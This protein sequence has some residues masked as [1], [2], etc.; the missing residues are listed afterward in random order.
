MR[1][2][3]PASSKLVKTAFDALPLGAIKPAGWLK[4]QLLIQASGFS[5]HLDE[6]WEDVGPRN[7]WIGGDGESWERG[8]Y[9]IDG[10]LPLA[11]LLEDEALIAKANKWVEWSLNSQQENGQFGPVDLKTINVEITKKHDWWHYMI[12]LKVMTQFAEVTGDERVEPFMTKFFRYVHQTIEQQ[13]LVE[14]AEARGAEMM[15]CIFWLYKRTGDQFLLELAAIVAKQTTDWTGLFTDFPFWNKV[16]HWDHRSHVVNVAMGIK[17]PGTL[18]EFTGDEKERD[19]V[20]RGIRSLMTYHGQ[21]HGM[22]SGDEWLSGTNPSQGVETCAVVEYMFSLENLVRIFG[23]GYFGDILEKVTFNALPAPISADWTSRQ[24]DQQVNQVACNIAHRNW[25][26]NDEA[27]LFGFDANFGCC[28]ANMHQGWPKFVSHLWMSHDNGLAAV[29]YAPN[30]VT[31]VV[32]AGTKAEL[33]VETDYPF[34]DT[35]AIKVSLD[36]TDRFPISLRIP[37][38]CGAPSISVNAETLAVRDENQFATLVREWKDGDVILLALPMEA[39][40]VNRNNGS[41]S[42]EQ[43]PLVYVLPIE[44]NWQLIKE[45]EKFSDWELFPASQWKYGIADGTAFETI[46]ADVPAQPFKAADSPVR[47]KVK[48]KFVRNWRMKGENADIPP[49]N[50]AADG[51]ELELVLVPYGSAKLRI[52]EFPVI[53]SK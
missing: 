29:A 28:T 20:Y 19:A 22:F 23:D 51:D 32:G 16:D 41:A 26:N 14:W 40:L 27:N 47:L 52:G 49:L 48:G 30:V 15:L 45:R 11:Y 35:I 44:E 33:T 8:P 53:R 5:G 31:T 13:P 10:L 3:N 42:V 18:F 21:A 25:S 9:Y 2:L 43:G 4:D 1:T 36:K 24:Y 50:P 6:H 7:G 34:R 46:T 39:K 12:M 38:W 17:T 37:A